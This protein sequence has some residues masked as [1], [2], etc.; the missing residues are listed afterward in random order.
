MKYEDFI[1]AHTSVRARSKHLEDTLNVACFQWFSLSYPALRGL[2]FHTP[3]EGRK[4]KAEAAR[5][6]RMG[7]VAGV[8]DLILLPHKEGVKPICIELKTDTG[9]QSESQKKWQSAVSSHGSEYV[10]CRSLQEFIETIKNHLKD[11]EER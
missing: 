5:L 10:V 2:L 7:V 3:N 1:K 4:G 9:R 6:K 11:Y 8:S